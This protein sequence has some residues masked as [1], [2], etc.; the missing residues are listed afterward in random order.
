MPQAQD[1]GASVVPSIIA[2]TL[3]F[4]L[5]RGPP[6]ASRRIAFQASAS[7]T[8]S[9]NFRRRHPTTTKYQ[10]SSNIIHRCRQCDEAHPTCRNCQ[11]SKRECLGYDPVFKSTGPTPIQPAPSAATASS[12]KSASPSLP[13]SGSYSPS[14]TYSSTATGFITSPHSAHADT[15]FE[16]APS[17]DPA[18]GPGEQPFAMSQPVG[19][20]LQAARKGSLPTL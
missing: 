7:E 17:L 9:A 5:F 19:P 15:T 12:T 1:Q 18:L 13:H 8:V 14:Q 4:W 20:S 10:T 11:K 3:E 6:G 16:F 2:S